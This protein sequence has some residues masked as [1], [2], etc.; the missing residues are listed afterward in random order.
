MKK[1]MKFVST[2]DNRSI[3][4]WLNNKDLSALDTPFLDKE[5]NLMTSNINEK[6]SIAHDFFKNLCRRPTR[7]QILMRRLN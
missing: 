2:N 1:Q 7:M 5:K 6:L 4:K 3:W